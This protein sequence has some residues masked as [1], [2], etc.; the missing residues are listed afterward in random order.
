M[1]SIWN[2]EYAQEA[3]RVL[4]IEDDEV[5]AKLVEKR[6]VRKGF[7][8]TICNRPKQGL[9]L[10]RTEQFH[11]VLIDYHLP[12]LSGQEL[13]VEANKDPERPPIVVMS[14]ENDLRTVVEAIRAG[15]ED[16]IV[17][18][19]QGDYFEL[20]FATLGRVLQQRRIREAGK[21]A[22][23]AYWRQAELLRNIID[24]IPFSIFW[25]DANGAYQGCNRAFSNEL[26]LEHPDDIID[27]DD[28]MVHPKDEAIIH[29]ENDRKIMRTG[30]GM[31]DV[32]QTISDAHGSRVQ[33]ISKVPLWDHHQNAVGVLGIYTDI[34]E[35]KEMERFNQEF[36]KKLR[37]KNREL[38]RKN[39]EIIKAQS[40]LISQEKMASLGTMAAGIAHEIRNPL[41]FIQNM[42]QVSVDYLKELRV[43]M[44]EEQDAFTPEAYEDI[45]MILEDLTN[46]AEVIHKH[47]NRAARVVQTMSDL[48]SDHSNRHAPM[49][50]NALVH[51][52]LHLIQDC[53]S[54]EGLTIE[55]DLEDDIGQIQMMG[56][57]MGRA[58]MN[59]LN[60]AFDALGEQQAEDPSH[61]PRLR[62]RTRSS[63]SHVELLICDNGIGIPLEDR[64]RIFEPFFTTKPSGKGNIGMGLAMSYEIIV[65]EHGGELDVD[66]IEGEGTTFTIR[67]PRSPELY[68]SQ[69]A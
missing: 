65:L 47:G 13:I 23:A 64:E 48:A 58:L 15:A 27:K 11:V 1:K 69:S 44:G 45:N 5:Y 68:L 3:P 36:T 51:E 49:N 20:L 55:T 4:Y 37:D 19:N 2:P 57:N 31:L 8:V 14:A 62:L 28:Y 16:Y 10:I 53:R 54:L 52:Y 50:F 38:S 12:G 29:R 25:K 18:S 39:E 61:L 33:L 17:K 24:N 66:V 40:R 67:L 34:T 60:N 6:L 56:H 42:S 26:G 59:M 21:K 32:E 30:E 22:E 46:N 7:E 35:R 41:N 9:E 43:V 63:E